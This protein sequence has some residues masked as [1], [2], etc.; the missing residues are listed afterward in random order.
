M[1]SVLIAMGEY[2]DAD[3]LLKGLLEKHTHFGPAWNNKAIIEARRENWAEAAT[4]IAKAEESGFEVP[5]EFKAEVQAQ[6]G[7]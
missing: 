7:K 4:C 1:S 2:E 5:E 6:G 3:Q